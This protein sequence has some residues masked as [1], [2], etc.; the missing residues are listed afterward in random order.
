LKENNNSDVIYKIQKTTRKA[1]FLNTY[2]QLIDNTK[3][4]IENCK[5]IVECND[6]LVKLLTA[7]FDIQIWGTNLTIS[8][9]NKEFVIVNGKISSIELLPRGRSRKNDL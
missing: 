3:A 9:Y 7:D 1:L 6:I 5:H 2:I 4:I 8:D